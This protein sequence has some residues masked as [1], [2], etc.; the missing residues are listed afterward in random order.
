MKTIKIP[1]YTSTLD[2]HVDEKNLEAEI[3]S[4]TDE[5]K[6]TK[7]EAEIVEEAKSNWSSSTM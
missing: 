1:F 3:Y 6:V 5:Y 4:K 7:T 2:L